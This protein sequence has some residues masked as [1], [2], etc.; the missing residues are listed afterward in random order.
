MADNDTP[1][2]L[3]ENQRTGTRQSIYD[4][5]HGARHAKLEKNPDAGPDNAIKFNRDL[6]IPVDPNE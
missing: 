1:P 5:A 2:Q 4:L 3:Y 6:Y